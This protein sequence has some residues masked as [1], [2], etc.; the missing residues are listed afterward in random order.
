[1][2]NAPLA[3][4][5]RTT[6]SGSP[7]FPYVDYHPAL[8]LLGVP[9]PGRRPV[10]RAAALLEGHRNHG[11]HRL[12]PHLG[13]GTGSTS[14]RSIPLGQVYNNPKAGQIRRFQGARDVPR[15]RRA[16]AGGPGSRPASDSGRPVGA[17][18]RTGEHASPI[19]AIRSCAS[20]RRAT[21]SPGRSSCSRAP[22]YSVPITGYYQALDP[23][24]RVLA[25]RPPTACPRPGT[26]TCPPGAVLMPEER[27]AAGHAG[28]RAARSPRARVAAVARRRRSSA[29]LPA[30]RDEIPPP[31]KRAR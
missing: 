4:S 25:S 13:A 11:R 19:P 15:L 24:G 28:P 9:R 10:Q 20:A 21:S 5:A 22:A 6:R 31:A 12:H 18:G 30:V 27:S 23:G 14:G 2:S 7:S 16:S 3:G 29:K 17:P 1:M 8:P 26:S